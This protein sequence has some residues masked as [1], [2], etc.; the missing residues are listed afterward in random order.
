MTKNQAEEMEMSESAMEDVM[1]LLPRHRLEMIHRVA[2]RLLSLE[3]SGGARGKVP[4]TR[5]KAV[6]PSSRAMSAGRKI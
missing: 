3:P 5:K 4:K 1:E 2:S 6:R